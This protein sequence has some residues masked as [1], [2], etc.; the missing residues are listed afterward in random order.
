VIK[1]STPVLF[2]KKSAAAVIHSLGLA[3]HSILIFV[4]LLFALLFYTFIVSIVRFNTAAVTT[5]PHPIT[6]RPDSAAFG[7]Y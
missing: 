1:K 3:D 6:F 7:T 4:K 2:S 5:H